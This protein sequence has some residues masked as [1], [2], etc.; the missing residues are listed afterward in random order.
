MRMER[1]K[2]DT[3]LIHESNFNKQKTKIIDHVQFF[4]FDGDSN[5]KDDNVLCNLCLTLRRA[6]H[7]APFRRADGV[8]LDHRANERL[9]FSRD[10][11]KK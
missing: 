9:R 7:L 2:S 10:S 11:T 5:M 8:W 6:N 1:N 4:N 3:S